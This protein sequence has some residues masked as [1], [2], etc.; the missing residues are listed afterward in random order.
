MA[1]SQVIAHMGVRVDPADVEE[2][3]RELPTGASVLD[4]YSQMTTK[5][6]ARR[7]VVGS[8]LMEVHARA[9]HGDAW[10]P[11]RSP[12]GVQPV[13]GVWPRKPP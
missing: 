5:E 1:V 4:W 9:L 8:V 12:H 11:R 7:C 3:L 6:R 10:D 13:P 2:A